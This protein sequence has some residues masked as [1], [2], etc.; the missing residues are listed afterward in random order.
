MNFVDK[1]RP[2]SLK[3]IFGQETAILQLREN[4]KKPVLLHGSPGTGKTFK[5][6]RN[7]ADK[8]KI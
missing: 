2:N 1:Y 5:G 4:I 3:E 6:A 7:L 8:G